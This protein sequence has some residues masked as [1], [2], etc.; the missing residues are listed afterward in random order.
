MKT[1]RSST[2]ARHLCRRP[3]GRRIA[4]NTPA[5]IIGAKLRIADNGGAA[6]NGW[7]PTD[8]PSGRWGFA[9]ADNTDLRPGETV[10]G[11]RPSST[12]TRPPPRL[13][14]P[15]R[16]YALRT[17]PHTPIIGPHPRIVQINETAPPTQIPPGQTRHHCRFVH[18]R[19]SAR[20]RWGPLAEQR[21]RP[22][23][24]PAPLR[25]PPCGLPHCGQPRPHQQWV[26]THQRK[27]KLPA[28]RGR[29][30][31]N[32]HSSLSRKSRV[33]PLNGSV[34]SRPVHLS[35]IGTAK[36]SSSAGNSVG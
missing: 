25:N 20:R 36:S 8:L 7:T 14:A 5:P 28:R 29:S 16:T 26:D 34:N 21:R 11:Y 15:M 4:D 6:N 27:S 23:R 12:S 18:N 2:S 17:T 30:Y 31:S 13:P 24:L 35:S 9:K 10:A 33:S 1:G 19:Y 3:C 22:P 32:G